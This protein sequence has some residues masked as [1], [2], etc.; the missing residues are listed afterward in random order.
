VVSSDQPGLVVMEEPGYRYANLVYL[1][2]RK[3][4]QTPGSHL[5]V[6][7]RPTNSTHL[8]CVPPGWRVEP[9]IGGSFV[10]LW[11]QSRAVVDDSVISEGQGQFQ[12][13]ASVRDSTRYGGTRDK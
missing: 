8:Q 2:L 3:L 7:S 5:F 4:A 13:P 1:V 11:Q 12:G 9:P 6:R 10:G